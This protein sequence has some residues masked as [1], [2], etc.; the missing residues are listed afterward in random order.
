MSHDMNIS[1][2]KAA[3]AFRSRGKWQTSPW[4]EIANSINT[5]SEL[6]SSYRCDPGFICRNRC[7]HS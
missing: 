3:S 6:Q 7:S 4:H 5:F 1:M 2:L